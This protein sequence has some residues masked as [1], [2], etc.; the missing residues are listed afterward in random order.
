MEPP[1]SPRQGRAKKVL[2]EKPFDATP[3]LESSDLLEEIFFHLDPLELVKLQRVCRLWRSIIPKLARPSVYPLLAKRIMANL[4]NQVCVVPNVFLATEPR[5]IY[6]LA[7]V[8]KARLQVERLYAYLVGRGQAWPEVDPSVVRAD[9]TSMLRKQHTQAPTHVI[10]PLN[11]IIV[12]LPCD[13]FVM[14]QGQRIQC[15]CSDGLDLAGQACPEKACFMVRCSL[16]STHY[17][18]AVLG[19]VI[20]ATSYN[21]ALPAGVRPSVLS[22]VVGLHLPHYAIAMAQQSEI[23]RAFLEILRGN[24]V[25]CGSVEVATS[26]GTEPRDDLEADAVQGVGAAARVAVRRA[27]RAGRGVPAAPLVHPVTLARAP[28]DDEDDNRLARQRN[29]FRT[30]RAWL[31]VA[32]GLV[33]CGY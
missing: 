10:L 14:G 2:P 32:R 13:A 31:I 5:N 1:P 21:F 7:I 12:Y 15:N 19:I 4:P 28:Y 30:I 20:R 25:M 6:K 18:R 16:V 27:P 23:P 22:S 17:M 33:L 26:D 29:V 8:D 11:H 9:P 24:T 3:P